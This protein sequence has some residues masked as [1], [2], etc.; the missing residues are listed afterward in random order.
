MSTDRIE[1]GEGEVAK[2][3][4]RELLVIGFDGLHAVL[5]LMVLPR[6]V[7]KG[8]RLAIAGIDGLVK[9]ENFQV[10]RCTQTHEN[11]RR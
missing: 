7:E 8:R 2:G 5:L 11:A 1:L 10:V 4:M 9:E 3:R 6:V